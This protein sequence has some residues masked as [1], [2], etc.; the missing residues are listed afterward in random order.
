M[1]WKW[2]RLLK[3]FWGFFAAVYQIHQIV[4]FDM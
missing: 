4:D 3:K 2:Y 1:E